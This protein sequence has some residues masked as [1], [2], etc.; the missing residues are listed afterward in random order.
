MCLPTALHNTIANKVTA[1]AIEWER[2]L[3]KFK[4]TVA[5][6]TGFLTSTGMFQTQRNA[7]AKL[8]IAALPA[9]LILIMSL[10][11]IYI[12]LSGLSS[13]NFNFSSFK[14]KHISSPQYRR[15]LKNLKLTTFCEIVVQERGGGYIDF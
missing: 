2:V 1:S 14:K 13:T 8:I 10:V 4:F 6:A 11:I 7:H 3:V 5:Q 12:F 15:K 9:T